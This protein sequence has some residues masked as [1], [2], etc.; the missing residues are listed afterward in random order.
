MMLSILLPIYNKSENLELILNKFLN[1]TN[2][3]FELILSL[4]SPSEK[5]LNIVQN[6]I[7]SFKNKVIVV[8]NDKNKI[9]SEEIIDMVNISSGE[10]F[11]YCSEFL[12]FEA[13]FVEIFLKYK[14][15]FNTDVIEFSPKLE[16]YFSWSPKNRIKK[17][18]VFKSEELSKVIAYSFPLF[19]NKFFKKEVFLNISKNISIKANNSKFLLNLVYKMLLNIDSYVF[20]DQKFFVVKDV[21]IDKISFYTLNRNW[22]EIFEYM[23]QNRRNFTNEI[24][25]AKMYFFELFIPSL[26]GL[27]KQR[28]FKKIKKILWKES[29]IDLLIEKYAKFLKKLRDIEFNKSTNNYLFEN[30]EEAELIKLNLNKDKWKEIHKKL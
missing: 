5:Q 20:L 4:N 19:F 8:I 25:Y 24:L 23:L 22:S 15:K 9:L 7:K 17:N 27:H 16:S 29:Q 6:T 18:K 28:L 14:Q 11:I 10:Y 26:F 12:D 21:Y 3:D 30:T 1:Q 2:K 13:N